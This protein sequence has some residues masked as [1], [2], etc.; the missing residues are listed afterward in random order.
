MNSTVHDAILVCHFEPCR[1]FGR[2]LV[3]QTYSDSSH[4]SRVSYLS[5][6]ASPLIE[7][8]CFSFE[9]EDKISLCEGRGVVK[10][11]FRSF[12]AAFDLFCRGLLFI[13]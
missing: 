6:K 9:T 2:M 12:S 4:I 5:I 8:N 1:E 10:M 11:N 7:I 13:F 3:L